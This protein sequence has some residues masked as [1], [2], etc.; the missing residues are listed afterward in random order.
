MFIVPTFPH[1][2]KLKLTVEYRELPEHESQ[3]ATLAATAS[4]TQRW[5]KDPGLKDRHFAPRAKYYVDGNLVGEHLPKAALIS[6]T[7]YPV[8]RSPR[9]GLTAVQPDDP[10]YTR[11]C[12]E[13]GLGHLLTGT[14]SPGIP[15]GVHASSPLSGKMGPP[16]TN[17]TVP[18]TSPH[19]L[20]N[21]TSPVSGATLNG[22]NGTSDNAAA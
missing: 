22:I 3:L 15:N 12:K 5:R 1:L 4:A 14:P 2:R 19:P 18:S 8:E 17:G 6:T 10:D 11:L 7:P 13:Q 21:G 16:S 9:R 20:V